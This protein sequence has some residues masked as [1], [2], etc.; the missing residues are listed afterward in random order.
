MGSRIV[1]DWVSVILPLLT[2]LK[3][4]GSS[5]TLKDTLGELSQKS[6]NTLL[7]LKD[8]PSPTTLSVLD[9][10]KYACPKVVK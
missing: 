2:S 1:N 8:K 7:R 6:R 9:G 4:A 10:I 5:W 3:A